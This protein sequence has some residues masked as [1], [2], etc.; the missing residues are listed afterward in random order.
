[1]RDKLKEIVN[2]RDIIKTENLHYKS[3]IRIVYNFGECSL[4]NAF[5][6]IYMKDIYH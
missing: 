4:T 1:M 6:G 5:L 3:K 2:L